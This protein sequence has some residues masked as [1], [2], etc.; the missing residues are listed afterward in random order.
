[1]TGAR[2][3]VASLPV[4]DRELLGFDTEMLRVVEGLA[5]GDLGG[6]T[7]QP[8][9]VD[10]R[11]VVRN[12]DRRGPFEARPVPLRPSGTAGPDGDL[13]E[14]VDPERQDN[15]QRHPVLQRGLGDNDVGA[16]RERAVRPVERP[17][18]HEVAHRGRDRGL[19]AGRETARLL[20]VGRDAVAAEVQHTR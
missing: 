6:E 16:A 17:V 9:V 15:V 8:R 13:L 4:P 14:V 19:V 10:V 2:I 18:A 11:G 20:R 5:H 12:E 3:A 7:E 1:V